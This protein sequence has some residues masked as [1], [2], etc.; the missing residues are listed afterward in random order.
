MQTHYNPPPLPGLPLDLF[1]QY[2]A[3]YSAI[4]DS[5]LDTRAAYEV[6]E[7]LQQLE[8][9]LGRI[10][11][12]ERYSE[13]DLTRQMSRGIWGVAA[14]NGL[15][16]P[17]VALSGDT[18]GAAAVFENWFSKFRAVMMELQ[19][20][21]EAFY[22]G[23][24]RVADI[25]RRRP[26]RLPN[27]SSFQCPG[28]RDVRNQLIEHPEGGNSG[29]LQRSFS[30]GGPQGPVVKPQR[31]PGKEGVFPDAGLHA[32]ATEFAENLTST[33]RRALDSLPPKHG[34]SA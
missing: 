12:L 29:V 18:P 25:L 30:S 26:H 6:E 16:G 33:L 10:R 23:A 22:Y 28:V 9:I 34:Q 5:E 7:R 32:N 4:P 20:M 17:V 27:L 2:V 11:E 14:S 1:R 8:F 13:V 3:A 15:T 21:T 31:E 19:I 24:H